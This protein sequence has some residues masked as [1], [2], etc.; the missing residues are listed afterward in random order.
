MTAEAAKAAARM[1]VNILLVDDQPAKL[2]SYEV[3]LAPLN[4]KLVRANSARE[5]LKLLLRLDI[6][7]VLIDVDMP[8]IDGFHLAAMIREHPRFASTAIIFVSAVHFSQ[9]DTMK[10]YEMGAVDY[11]SVPVIPEVLRAKVRVFTDLYRKT[12]ELELFNEELERRVAARTKELEAAAERQMILAREVDHRAKNALAVVQAIIRLSRGKSFDD[13]VSSLEGRIGALARSHT[14]LSESRWKGVNF[15]KILQE[16][17]APYTGTGSSKVTIDCPAIV[18]APAAT[19]SLSLVVHELATNAAKYG[20]LSVRDGR[21]RVK[22]TIG[23]DHL[24]I[25]WEEQGVRATTKPSKTGFGTRLIDATME[26]LG[27]SAEHHWE[28]GGLVFTVSVPQASNLEGAFPRGRLDFI[29]TAQSAGDVTSPA[30]KFLVVEDEPLIGMMITSL[31]LEL[32]YEVLGPFGRLEQAMEAVAKETVLFALL[33][34]NVGGE[35][36]Y[37]LAALLERRGVRF[38]FVSGYSDAVI[39]GRF[40]SVP[41]LHK[42]IERGEFHAMVKGLSAERPPVHSVHE[43]MLRGT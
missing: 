24:R 37:P 16:E 12:R 8:E 39:D 38:A 13:Y 17:L 34:I 11:V 28:K 25:V 14:L 33:D 9:E 5:A 35:P 23:G 18:L 40:A 36:V 30:R 42:P 6:A 21:L 3:I 26:Q 7:V 29:G 20:A 41:V 2:L 31:L 10:G 4:E 19:Q 22:V 1:P 43:A 32:D 27:G 15:Q